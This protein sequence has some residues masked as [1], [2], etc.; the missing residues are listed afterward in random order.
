VREVLQ[1]LARHLHAFAADVG[2]QEGELA[3]AIDFLTRT[4]QTCTPTRQEFILL[5]D[6]LGLSMRVVGQSHPAGGAVT[7]STVLGP[8][9]VEGAPAFALG[10][11]LSGGAPGSPCLVR[12]TVRDEDGAPVAGARMEV[13]QA[14]DEGHYD[15][16]LDGLDGPRNR[17][18]LHTGADGGYAF[19]ASRPVAYPIPDDGP[20]GELLAAAGR[21]PWRPAHIHFMITAPGRAT[22]TTHVF[23]ASDA[24][25][26]DD[27][28]FGVKPSLVADFAEHPP[29][30]APDG[31]R[32]DEPWFSLDFDFVMARR[33]AR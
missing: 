31:R 15:V 22:I 5:S 6:V 4:G 12:G 18:H 1:S 11:D 2:L 30:E 9:F 27:A 20:V 26:D 16:Q 3:G 28:V 19:W 21:G 13:W 17:G 10:D 23:D 32:L 33:P 24:Y 14:D 29:G 8:F 7:E 25:L